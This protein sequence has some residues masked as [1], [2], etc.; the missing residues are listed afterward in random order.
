MTLA[1]K[2]IKE[3]FKK[4]GALGGKA[5]SERYGSE[6]YRK[7]ARLKEGT[8]WTWA[9]EKKGPRKNKIAKGLQSEEGGA[10]IPKLPNKQ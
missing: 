7:L 9:P 6:H 10:K 1:K 5:T 4:I 8:S 3:Y 2:D